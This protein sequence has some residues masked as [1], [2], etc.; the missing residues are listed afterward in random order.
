MKKIIKIFSL[1]IVT[2]FLVS[3]C[4]KEVDKDKAK[5][6]DKK[7]ND[8]SISYLTEITF[9]ELKEKLENKEDIVLEIVQTG[10]HNCTS[11]SPKFEEVLEEY[12]IEAYSLNI[13]LLD[14]D[15]KKWLDEYEVDGTPTVI[16]FK[17]GKEISKMK[18]MVGDQDKERIISKFKSNGYI[19]K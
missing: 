4:N 12:K 10:C 11:F 16:F 5:D 6:K 8:D 15:G 18:R 3:G 1:F 9:S 2:L 17:G 13:S 14:E 19:S 7:N